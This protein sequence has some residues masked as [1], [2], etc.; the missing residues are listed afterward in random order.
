MGSTVVSKLATSLTS[1][2]PGT[3]TVASPIA[4]NTIGAQ[5]SRSREAA[6]AGRSRSPSSA[7]RPRLRARAQLAARQWA[8]APC[9][10]TEPTTRASPSP[11]QR[12]GPIGGTPPTPGTPGVH[13]PTDVWGRNGQ[14]CG[15]QADHCAERSGS[16]HRAAGPRSSRA[17]SARRSPGPATRPA[18]PHV[19][20]LRAPGHGA[21]LVLHR[22]QDHRNR[23]R[24]RR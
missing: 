7:R 3:G 19:H 18:E 5:L 2:A 15:R 4:A 20:R 17:R 24:L 16:E 6:P 21:D 11:P 12:A 14:H 22:R 13:P 10:E 23:R 1:G 9:R 8:P